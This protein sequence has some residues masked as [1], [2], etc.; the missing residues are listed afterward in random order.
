[1]IP[2][3]VLALAAP[4][5][6]QPTQYPGYFITDDGRVISLKRSGSTRPSAEFAHILKTS[7]GAAGYPVALFSIAGSRVSESV[8]RLVLEAFVGPCPDGLVCCHNDDNPLNNCLPNLRWDTQKSN[9]ADCKRR[10]NLNRARGEQA[11]SSKL[12]E[13]Q[14]RSIRISLAQGSTC[15]EIAEK[16]N[17]TPEAIRSIKR[18]KSWGWLK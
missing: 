16:Y 2:Q 7:V 9:V 12:T 14:V 6:V 15:R 13:N 8:H 3:E 10:G 4:A 5:Q 1:M 11:G 18:G 17:V